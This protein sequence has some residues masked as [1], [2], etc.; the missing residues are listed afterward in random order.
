MDVE[1]ERRKPVAAD[2]IL[3]DAT[4]P[5]TFSRAVELM[6]ANSPALREANSEYQTAMVLTKIKTPLPNPAFEAGPRYGFGPDVGNVRPFIPFGSLGFTIPTGKRLKRQD[7]LNQVLAEVAYVEAQAKHRELYLELRKLYSRLMLARARS[8]SRESLAES[9][10]K[11]V[12]LGKRLAEAGQA[13]SLDTGLLELEYGRART[14][15]M[16]AGIEIASI[17]GEMSELVGVNAEHFKGV[18]EST[19]PGGTDLMSR[20]ELLKVLIFNHPQLARLRARYEAAERELHLEI[21]KQYPDFHFG[22]SFEGDAGARKHTIGLT[23]G[24]DIPVFDRNQQAVATALQR[25]EEVRTKYETAANKALS[26]LDQALRKFTLA[27]EKLKFLKS[28]LQPKA[29][30]NVELAKKSLE[31]GAGDALRFLETERAERSITIDV[32][33]SELNAREAWVDIEQAVGYPLTVFPGEKPNDFPTL[34]ESV[35]AP[36]EF[37]SDS[38]AEINPAKKEAQ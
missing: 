27:T 25:R 36:T 31:A 33:E 1:A 3:A 17:E 29:R 28:E 32:I 10:E 30:S 34:P 24:I 22:P 26:A 6:S 37:D 4:P 23:L 7:E 38:K 11:S 2:G 35:R 15:S 20:P 5:F 8:V 19:L 18:P 12:S 16:N 14:D 21:A 13:T 9:A